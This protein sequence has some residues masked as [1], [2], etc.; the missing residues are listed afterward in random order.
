MYT[1]IEVF[2]KSIAIKNELSDTGT[3]SDADVSEYKYRA[4]YL[5]DDVQHEIAHIEN[6]TGV[7]KITDLTTTMQISD[8]GCIACAYYLA[9]HYALSEADTDTADECEKEFESL[10]KTLKK[11]LPSVGIT[12]VYGISG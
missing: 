11:P 10:K 1:A 8:L 12:D 5:L 6:V 2:N 7:N 3:I 4:P 9:K